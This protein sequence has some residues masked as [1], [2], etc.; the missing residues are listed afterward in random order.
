M[1]VA[2]QG[3]LLI[4]GAQQLEYKDNIQSFIIHSLHFS[5]HRPCAKDQ[6]MAKPLSSL[7]EKCAYLMAP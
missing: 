3:D 7:L 6:M 4:P 1:Y 2:A 5:Y